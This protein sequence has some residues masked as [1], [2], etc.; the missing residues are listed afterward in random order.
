MNPQHILI[1]GAAGAI[2]SMLAAQFRNHHPSA[3]LTLVDMNESSLADIANRYGG[4]PERCD[5]TDIEALPRWWHSLTE[6][7]GPV[8]VLINCA[9][10]MDIMTIT[11][12]GWE[13]GQRSLDINLIAPMRLMDLALPD[14]LAKRQG[15]VINIASMAGRVPIRG[16]S[17][18]GGA[19]AGIGMASEI[20]RLD[21]KK[22]GINV[23][24]VYPGPIF[25]G[26]E[27]HARSQVK[28]GPISRL[29]PTGKPDVLAQRIYQTFRK[30]GA[31]VIYPDIYHLAKQLANLE[32][33]THV[34]DR[35]SPQPNR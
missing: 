28:Q 11:G 2:G 4:H 16:C 19:K 7:Q 6:R 5:L 29:I 34:M 32:L 9:G 31:R 30:G 22:Q 20:A 26:L 10:I 13:R 15:C 18:Y 1:T 27:N 25:S 14:M 8:D 23:I 21:L 12:T 24:T 35:F 3:K 17:Y 33:T